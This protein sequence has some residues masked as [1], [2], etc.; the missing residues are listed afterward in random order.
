MRRPRS[1]RAGEPP[2]WLARLRWRVRGDSARLAFVAGVA[3]GALLLVVLPPGGAPGLSWPR[4]AGL[5]GV[6]AGLALLGAAVGS[7]VLRRRDPSLPR[8]VARDRAAT[9]AIGVGVLGLCVGGILH[10]PAVVAEQERYDGMVAVAVR[11]AERRAPEYATDRLDEADVRRL[12]RDVLRV[13][14]P[15]GRPDRAWCAIARRD[16]G[17]PRARTD[18]DTRPNAQVAEEGDDGD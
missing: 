5:I 8:L 6:V 1:A 4:F 15:L 12:S 10:R 7:R 3:A 14:F 11:L 2:L 13:C 17:V 16:G 18:S 9:L